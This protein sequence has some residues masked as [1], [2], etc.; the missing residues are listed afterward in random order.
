[1]KRATYIILAALSF[2]VLATAQDVTYN[3]DRSTDFSQF[4]TY[5]WI[6]IPGGAQVNPLLESQLRSALEAQLVQKGLMKTT[7]ATADLLVGYQLGLDKERQ[8]NFYG[9]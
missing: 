7:T 3:Y 9:M 2:S 8:V 6:D 4:H 5:K 1:M